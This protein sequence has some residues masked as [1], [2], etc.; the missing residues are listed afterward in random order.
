MWDSPAWFFT[1]YFPKPEIQPGTVDVCGRRC[2]FHCSLERCTCGVYMMGSVGGEGLSVSALDEVVSYKGVAG[3]LRHKVEV[4]G[5]VIFK[6]IG[7]EREAHL[8]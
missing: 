5:S 4:G 8:K 3:R 2:P 6:V 1:A 7:V